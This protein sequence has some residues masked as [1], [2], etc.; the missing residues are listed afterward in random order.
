MIFNTT[1]DAIKHLKTN[2]QEFIGLIP[3]PKN[4]YILI[5]HLHIGSKTSK[6]VHCSPGT[7]NSH[8]HEETEVLRKLFYNPEEQLS[9]KF[10]SLLPRRIYNL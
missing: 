9:P 5:I 6:T 3:D 1:S 4:L 10:I 7:P 2:T 8:N